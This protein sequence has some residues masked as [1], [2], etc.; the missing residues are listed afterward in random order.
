VLVDSLNEEAQLNKVGFQMTE[1]RLAALLVDRLRLRQY[2]KD[3]RRSS[4]RTAGSRV[5]FHESHE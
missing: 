1:R 5:R 2:Q 3:N 4:T